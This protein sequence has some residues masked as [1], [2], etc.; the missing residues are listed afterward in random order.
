MAQNKNL[1][2]Y[3]S[4][5]NIS[6]ILRDSGIVLFASRFTHVNDTLEYNWAKNAIQPQF[7]DLCRQYNLTYDKDMNGYPFILCFSKAI[8]Y[9][10]L[11]QLYAQNGYG[12]CLVFDR[13][14]IEQ[15]ALYESDSDNYRTNP[16]ILMDICYSDDKHIEIDYVK[17][18]KQYMSNFNGGYSGDLLDVCA[19]IKRNIFKYESETRYMRMNYNV[20]NFSNGKVSEYEKTN[21]IF[22]R[23]SKEGITPFYEICFPKNCLKRII[24]GYKLNF[25]SQKRALKLLLNQRGYNDVKIIPSR[26]RP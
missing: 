9:F 23:T 22:F 25:E 14:E 11:W 17:V 8:D 21:S 3:T 5:A 19:F 2:H 7:K 1:C 24:I 20:I 15:S 16:D 13:A 26:N 18:A 4:A 12:Y 6:S 10:L